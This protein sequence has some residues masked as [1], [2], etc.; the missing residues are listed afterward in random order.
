MTMLRRHPGRLVLA[1]LA[2][3]GPAHAIQVCDLDG[4]HVNPANGSTTAGKTGLMRCR[5]SDTKLVVLEQELRDGK[6]MGVVRYFKNGQLE[7]E[8]SVDERGNRTGLSREW[9]VDANGARVLV[10]EETVRDGRPVGLVRTWFASGPRRRLA[11]YGDDGREQAVVEFTPAGQLAELRCGPQPAFGTEFDDA[12]ACGH[13]GGVST[14]LL[15]GSKGQPQTRIVFERGE[16]RKVESLWE[17]GAVRDSRETT[18]TGSVERRFAADGT[19]LREVHWA[20]QPAHTPDAGA[21][22]RSIKVLEQEYHASGKLVREARWVPDERAG[23]LLASE[24]RWY[25]NG[26]PKERVEYTSDADSKRTRRETRFHDN[27]QPSFEGR[28]SLGGR[29]DR[30]EL[31]LGTHRHFDEQGRVRLERVHDDRGRVGR[32]RE[33]DAAGTLLRDDELFED[34]SRKS[35]ALR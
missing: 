12:T 21:R 3:T 25:L 22:P 5:D 10:L 33:F 16:R 1:A 32:E 2:L 20:T 30:S 11:A 28:W 31:A 14:V 23:A 26:Q 18:P 24:S 29:S 4:Q 9:N 17:N 27:G 15:H 19:K 8:H 35:S 13:A 6:F 34:G 7:R